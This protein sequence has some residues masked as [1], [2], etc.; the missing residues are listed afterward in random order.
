MSNREWSKLR[1]EGKC[2][3]CKKK[4]NITRNCPEIDE[5][6]NS[7]KDSNSNSEYTEEYSDSNEYDSENEI[8]NDVVPQQKNQVYRSQNR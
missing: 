6:N 3:N 1:A 7:E 4:G 5:I 8:S 2:F